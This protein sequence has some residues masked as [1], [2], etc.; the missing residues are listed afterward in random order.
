MDTLT[1]TF[2]GATL[3]GAVHKEEENRSFKFS[4]L[5]SSITASNIPD[6]DVISQLWDSEGLYQMW[7]RGVT[8]SFF[9]VP[10]WAIIIS[11]VCWSIWRVDFRKL[12]P[13]TFFAVLLHVLFDALNTWG[14]GLFEPFSQV[15][16]S[17]G[18]IPIV[19]FV[20]WGMMAAGVIIIKTTKLKPYLVFQWVWVFI[21]AHV[22]AQAAQGYAVYESA[23]GAYHEHVISAS[24]VPGKF[25][26]IGKKD[27][28]VEIAEASA[29]STAQ[30]KH[31]LHTE[32]HVDLDPLFTQNKK[33]ETLY[34]WA[35]FVVIVDNAEEMA[36]YDP[37]FF[38]NGSSFLYESIKK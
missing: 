3:Y 5:F 18:V 7:H 21:F 25:N 31:Q 15:R 20:I 32:D 38:R 10:I 9:M 16:F 28:I 4:L 26:V 23:K 37:R 1:H 36:I 12:F 22:M 11:V 27:G 35:P 30:M 14:T 17:Y 2:M 13:V 29:W 6:S 34:R 8:H 33:A 24:F 19:D